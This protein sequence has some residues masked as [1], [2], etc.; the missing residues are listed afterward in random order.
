[1]ESILLGA[2]SQIVTIITGAVFTGLGTLCAFYVNRLINRLKRRD[3]VEEVSRYVRWVE[4]SPSY[5]N[6]S[7]EDKFN[8]VFSRARMHAT[9]YGIPMDDEKI[10]I[11]VE[12]AVKQ[13]KE[14]EGKKV[15]GEKEYVG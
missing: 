11:I 6:Y 15:K 13:M 7:N 2:T 1:M 10:T 3:L 8:I 4:Q 9:Q 5:E 14:A 12:S